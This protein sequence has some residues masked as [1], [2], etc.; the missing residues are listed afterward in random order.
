MDVCGRNRNQRTRRTGRTNRGQACL[1]LASIGFTL[2]IL[3]PGALADEVTMA[4]GDVITGE[5]LTLKE[6]KLTI[7]TPYNEALEV[8]WGSIKKIQSETPVEVVLSDDTR[9]QGPLQMGEDGVL[10]VVTESAGPIA[11][12]EMALITDINPP[13]VP[14]VTYEGN[15]DAGVSY[16]T[17]NTDTVSGNLVRVVRGKEQT[18]A[19][20][21]T[22]KMVLRRERQ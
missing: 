9:L 1:L 11:V 2:L 12:G 22:W 7:K 6:G 18:T 19:L 13:V 14:A 16:L 15:L 21:V 17:G 8:A 3:C 5:I 4:N 20:H 10:Q